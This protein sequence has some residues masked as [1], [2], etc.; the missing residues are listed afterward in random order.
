[1]AQ[2]RDCLIEGRRRP[3]TSFRDDPALAL[4]DREFER[5]KDALL[6]RNVGLPPRL[7]RPLLERHGAAIRRLRR[8]HGRFERVRSARGPVAVADGLTW[9]AVFSTRDLLRELPAHFLRDYRLL[10]P[11]ELIAIAASNYATAADRRITAHRAREARELQR[12]YLELIETAARCGGIS[13]PL[14]LTEVAGRSAV[15]NRYD[16]VT[17]DAALHVARRLLRQR[18]RLGAQR[19]TELVERFVELQTLIPERKHSARAR[20]DDDPDVRRVLGFAAEVVEELRYG[21]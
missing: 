10:D 12:A 5:T 18:K 3:L 21:L 9:N 2:I 16:R 4:F 14:L 7:W 8:V 19:L 15:I 17:G 11:A 1:V 6:L 13:V 20:E